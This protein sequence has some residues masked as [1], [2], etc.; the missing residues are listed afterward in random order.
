MRLLTRGIALAALAAGAAAGIHATHTVLG[1]RVANAAPAESALVKAPRFEVDPLWPKPLPNHWVMGQAVGVAIDAQDHIF[2]V[3]R[4]ASVWRPT[5]AGAAAEPPIAECCVPAPPVLEFDEAG[6]LIGHWGGPGEGY[7]WPAVEHGIAIDPKGNVWLGANGATDRQILEFTHDGKF[8]KQ[9]GKPG[10]GTPNS[11]STTD[12]AGVAMMSFDPKTGEAYVADGYRNHRVA[13]VDPNT[14]KIERFWGAYGHTPNDDR[15]APYKPSDPPAQQFGTPVHCAMLSNDGLV[16]VA[17]RKNDRLQ[18]FHKD[19][20]FIKEKIIA[21]NTLGDGSV[22]EV[23][24]S[25]DPAQK[26]MYITDGKNERIYV[27]D[28]QS[29]DVL[30]TFGDGGRQPGEFYGVHS[31][32]VDSH[33][34]IFTAETYE[35]RRVQKFDYKGISMVPREQG[36]VWPKR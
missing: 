4:P 25:T 8:I 24:F 18:V 12:F 6:N 2:I 22:W 1:A 29:L 5:E 13:V 19:G 35:G 14:G 36:V 30:T 33:G 20:S 28:R 31:I 26:Y 10:E 17:D 32:A 7:D 9:I 27:L 34:N 23:G 16:Y 11:L 3:H 21:P 15:Q